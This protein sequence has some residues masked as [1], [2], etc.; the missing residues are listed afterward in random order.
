MPFLDEVTLHLVSGKG[1]NGCVSFAREKHMPR[2]G[3]DGGNG[4]DGGD[5][6]MVARVNRNTFDDLKGRR[7][8]RAGS[9]GPGDANNR[10]GRRGDDLLIELPVGTI[11]KDAARGHVLLELLEPD[12][13]VAIL[14]GGKGGRGNHS[15]KGPSRQTPR[16]CDPGAPATERRV[17]LE[18][19]LLADV[20]LVGLPNAGKSTLL[21]KISAARP[22][23]ADYPFTT[24][25]PRIGVVEHDWRQITVADLPGLIEGASAGKGLGH[26]FLRHVERTRVLVHLV[27]ASSGDAEAIAAAWRS[28][29]E[30][31]AAY[32]ERVAAKPEVLVLSK[33]DARSGSLPVAE[34][35]RLTGQEP[36][37]LSSHD[38]RGIEELVRRLFEVAG[39][40]L[41]A[42]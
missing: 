2:G 11:V 40:G 38:G 28:V 36:V 5:V 21:A 18:L 15:F 24:L 35:A 8:W 32:G 1:G 17:K 22:K 13:P 42:A 19:Q 30:E 9:G 23:I 37:L 14:Q 27:D 29:R 41:G 39:A 4:G 33:V 10:A 34:V 26:Q 20:G 7:L 12:V 25:Q 16:N 6:L 31:L 3:P